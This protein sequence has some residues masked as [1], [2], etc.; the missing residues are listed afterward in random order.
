MKKRRTHGILILFLCMIEIIIG[1]VIA[2][3]FLLGAISQKRI[4][5]PIEYS[6]VV[7]VK[8]D[9]ITSDMESID[10]DNVDIENM[11]TKDSEIIDNVKLDEK[12]QQNS[13]DYSNVTCEVTHDLDTI[14]GEK[15]GIINAVESS[16]IK[17]EG[18]SNTAYQ[19]YDGDLSTSWQEGVDGPGLG[20]WLYYK[21]DG[22]H[23]ISDIVVY[24]GIWREAEG[25]D[26]YHDNYRP[27][28]IQITIMES[29]SNDLKWNVFFDDN[30]L[31]QVIHFSKA[32]PAQDISI[33]ILDAYK[34]NKYEDMGI[35]E[36]AAYE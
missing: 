15:I 30:K 27:K 16:V 4:L 12:S 10:H 17:Q 3:Q 28:E 5:H 36:I 24:A 21:F 33:T 9:D 2:Q 35:A 34:G 8:K 29:A 18:Y 26:Y 22:V 14:T 1:V 6:V 31:P 25:K 32:V 11:D 20:S 19:A 13:E 23:Y 7:N